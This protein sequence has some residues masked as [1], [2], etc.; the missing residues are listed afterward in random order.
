LKNVSL[1]FGK[2]E[3]TSNVAT[4]DFVKLNINGGSIFVIRDLKLMMKYDLF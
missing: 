1:P 3:S 4:S 2:K